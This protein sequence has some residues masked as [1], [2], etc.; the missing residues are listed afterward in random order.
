MAQLD[1]SIILQAGRG[2]TPLMSPA[3]IEEQQ[4]TRAM[5]QMQMRWLVVNCA[6]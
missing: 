3:E 5:R 4:A 6:T 2:V 1:P